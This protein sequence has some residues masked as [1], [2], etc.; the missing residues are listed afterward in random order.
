MPGFSVDLRASPA[1]HSTMRS[2][3]RRHPV[4]VFFALTFLLTWAVWVPRAL[5]SQ[6]R[7]QAGW[8][9]D[10]APLSTYGPAVA[11]LI[12]AA[13]VGGGAVRDLGGRLVRWR[14]G[15]QWY[16]VVLLGPVAFWAVVWA[17]LELLGWESTASRPL[18]LEEGLAAALPL[19]LVLTLT[20]G[21]G[22]ETGWRGFAL[23]RLLVR[24]TALIASALL[25][26]PG[27]CAD[28]DPLPRR[29]EPVDDERLGRRPRRP[30]GDC[31]GPPAQVAARGGGRRRMAQESRFCAGGG[32]PPHR[33]HRCRQVTG[34][35]PRQ[36]N[37]ARIVP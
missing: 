8:P 12:V 11:A 31:S 20:D 21:L 19:L 33:N 15:W 17:L 9:A 16:A 26:H 25:G 18:L 27:Q 22:E 7:M 10:V 24:H 3:A 13:L 14:V 32:H 28:G 34:P 6:D 23:P 1:Q 37:R 36:P 29:V 4:T 30:T 5:V 2:L 35:S